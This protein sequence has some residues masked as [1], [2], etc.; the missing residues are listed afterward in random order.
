MNSIENKKKKIIDLI[1]K[2]GKQGP[3]IA[4]YSDPK[5]SS[6]INELY[7]RWENRGRSG[8]PI[9]YATAEEIDFLYSMAIK[10]SNISDEEAWFYF[11]SREEGSIEERN[12]VVKE[13]KSI[14]KRIFWF[15]IPS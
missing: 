1:D 14:W 2:C 6:L 11:I 8:L 10:Y 7:K 15:L 12:K 3:K 5:V 4:F 9:D 13:K